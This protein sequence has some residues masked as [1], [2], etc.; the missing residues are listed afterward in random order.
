VAG[1]LANSDAGVGELYSKSRDLHTLLGRATAPL[2][3]AVRAAVARRKWSG[4]GA[5][6]L[7][8]GGGQPQIPFG[9]DNKNAWKTKRHGRSCVA[10]YF[11]AGRNAEGLSCAVHD[12]TVN[13]AGRDEGF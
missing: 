9:N 2:A 1:S 6:L 8:R 7:W 3:E 4:V 12:E 10:C 13:R 11:A 5:D